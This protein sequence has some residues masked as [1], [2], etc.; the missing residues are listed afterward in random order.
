MKHQI[1]FAILFLIGQCVFAQFDELAPALYHN[2]AGGDTIYMHT[3]VDER[4]SYVKGS[5][6]FR[7]DYFGMLK[8][9]AYARE[10]G[11]QG[12]VVISFIVEKDGSISDPKVVRSVHTL[13]D[14]EAMKTFKNSGAWK[15]AILHGKPVRC[16]VL[17]PVVFKLG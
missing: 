13:L 10:K 15:P 9:P 16:Q 7:Q 2:P 12:K 17:L 5:D 14:N 3:D 11:I 1:A 4:A 8:Y 6:A